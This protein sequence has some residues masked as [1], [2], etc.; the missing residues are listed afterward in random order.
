MKI[1]EV[2]RRQLAQLFPEAFTGA[3]DA[4]TGELEDALDWEKLR[5]SPGEVLEGGGER[6]GH[7]RPGKSAPRRVIQQANVGTLRP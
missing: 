2:K 7:S 5:A 1:T 4:R 3:R 6:F